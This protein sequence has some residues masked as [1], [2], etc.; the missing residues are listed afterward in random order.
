MYIFIY[1]YIIQLTAV[2]YKDIEEPVDLTQI[3]PVLSMKPAMKS[4]P[5]KQNS[6]ADEGRI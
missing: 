3:K 5:V 2:N 1:L 4:K 6:T